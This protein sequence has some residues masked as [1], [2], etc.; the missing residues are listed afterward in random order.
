MLPVSVGRR[1]VQATRSVCG[2]VA[3]EAVGSGAYLSILPCS[4]RPM[5]ATFTKSSGLTS[6][7]VGTDMMV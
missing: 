5:R 3:V 7:A 1:S 2:H 6:A 4:N